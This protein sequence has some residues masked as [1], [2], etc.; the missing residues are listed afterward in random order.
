MEQALKY[1]LKQR[2]EQLTY[3]EYIDAI[4]VLPEI[5]GISSSTFRQYMHARIDEEFSIPVDDLICLADYLDCQV[6]DL[7]AY[8]LKQ[9]APKNI[10]KPERNA[11]IKKFNLVK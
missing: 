5:L 3:T 10:L 6:K 4:K 7:I 9:H 11:I 8:K 2:L 1:N